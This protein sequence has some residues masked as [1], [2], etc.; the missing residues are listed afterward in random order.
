MAGQ[1]GEPRFSP[2]GSWAWGDEMIYRKS[3]CTELFPPHFRLWTYQTTL[4][5][6]RW[7]G[8]FSTSCR[9]SESARTEVTGIRTR[10][11]EGPRVKYFVRDCG[12]HGADFAPQISL[13]WHFMYVAFTSHHSYLAWTEGQPQGSGERQVTGLGMKSLQQKSHAGITDFVIS[14]TLSV[15]LIN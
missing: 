10:E 5:S 15:P 11:T 7:F 14:K 13:K 12:V 2:Y 3:L 9:Q 8:F 1:E 6:S 4:R